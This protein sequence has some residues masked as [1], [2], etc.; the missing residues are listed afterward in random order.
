MSLFN[1]MFRNL[2]ALLMIVSLITGCISTPPSSTTDVRS[3]LLT[4]ARRDDPD[5][6][7]GKSMV[8]THF[9]HVGQLE[10]SRGEMVY[11]ADRRAVISGM[12]APRGQ[13]YITFFDKDFRYLG[14]IRYGSSRPLWCDASRLYL[15]GALDGSSADL[16]GN[17]IDIAG[18]YNHLVAYQRRAYGSSGGI[19]D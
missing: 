12:M 11:V 1:A 18:G 13:N 2:G 17:V 16:S 8:L 14:K 7:D 4:S 3:S 6:P 19:D 5:F 15:F 10:S 9:S